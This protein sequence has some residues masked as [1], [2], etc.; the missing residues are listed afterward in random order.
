MMDM[1]APHGWDDGQLTC[2]RLVKRW[3]KPTPQRVRFIALIGHFMQHEPNSSFSRKAW[4]LHFGNVA[5]ARAI[6]AYGVVW[7]V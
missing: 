2:F 5:R 7:D 6:E 4:C 1:V 3:C